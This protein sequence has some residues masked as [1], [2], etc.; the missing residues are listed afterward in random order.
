MFV[1]FTIIL[2][3]LKDKSFILSIILYVLSYLIPSRYVILI[4][5]L[6]IMS[7]TYLE[8]YLSKIW[9]YCRILTGYQIFTP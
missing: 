9:L 3:S 8:F 6:N 5:D 2:L 4:V 1:G 7:F